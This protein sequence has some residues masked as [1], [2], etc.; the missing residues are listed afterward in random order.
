MKHTRKQPVP[1]LW[2]MLSL[3]KPA[4]FLSGDSVAIRQALSLAYASV[5]GWRNGVM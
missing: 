3:A 4:R 2:K 5:M 1:N